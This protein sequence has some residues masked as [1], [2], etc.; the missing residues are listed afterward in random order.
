MTRPLKIGQIGFGGIGS[1]V[2][3]MLSEDDDIAYA[4][5]ATRRSQNRAIKNGLPE[6]KF[7]ESPDALIATQPDL[8]IECGSHEAL[9]TY[10]APVLKAGIDLLAVS[11]GILADQN[12]RLL[13]IAAA[14]EGNSSLEIPAG[15]VGGIDVVSA[16]RHSGINRITYV[17][18]KAPSLWVRTPAEGMLDLSKVTEPIMFF[19]GTAGEG[20]K[21]FDEKLNVAAT[22]ALAGIGFE[23]TTVE[24]WADP[25][26]PQSTHFIKMEAESGTMNIELTNTVTS[27]N[28]KSSL[29]TAAAIAQAVKRRRA[30]IKF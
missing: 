24:L 22:I 2:A 1:T 18:K 9:R 14:E 4:A 13:L 29:L 25:E 6:T 12:E 30:R 5:V 19:Q 15:A 10:G 16:A 11:V 26:Y 28:K 3:E 17:T 27:I 23:R 20:A 21:I 8:V 7:V